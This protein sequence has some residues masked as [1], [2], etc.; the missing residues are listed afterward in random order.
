MSEQT[1]IEIK[2]TIGRSAYKV[3]ELPDELNIDINKYQSH[4]DCKTLVCFVYDP[5]ERIIN[6]RGLEKDLEQI[7]D[8]IKV[9]VFIRHS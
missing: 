9:K 7:T 3:K 2:T 8:K 6:P 4:P 1:A 5:K